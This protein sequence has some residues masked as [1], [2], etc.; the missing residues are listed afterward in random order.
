MFSEFLHPQGNQQYHYMLHLE[1]SLFAQMQLYFSYFSSDKPLTMVDLCC[2]EGTNAQII[3]AAIKDA[4]QVPSIR[5]FG[6]DIQSESI[7]KMTQVINFLKSKGIL[8]DLSM[9]VAQDVFEEG[10][11]LFK[12]NKTDVLTLRHGLYYMKT[13]VDGRA[14]QNFAQKTHEYTKVNNFLKN[15]MNQI[16]DDGF[17]LMF[18]ETE[19]SDL[20]S[21]QFN[22]VCKDGSITPKMIDAAERIEIA[23]RANNYKLVQIKFAPKLYFPELSNKEMTQLK[24]VRNKTQ[25]DVLNTQQKRWVKLLMFAIQPPEKEFDQF[26]SSGAF[27]EY[28]SKAER[29]HASNFRQIMNN[30]QEPPYFFILQ[31]MQAITCSTDTAAKLQTICFS[32]QNAVNSGAVLKNIE[33]IIFDKN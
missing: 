22:Y 15:I 33:N 7:H 23:A 11:D 12:N 9:A 21:E 1:Y 25:L 17:A 6:K 30:V 24:T 5:Y 13:D 4:T 31:S 10:V 2:G 20:F 28:V 14:T 8:D 3:I 16:K 19:T 29:I 18:H 32:L 27:K 26:L